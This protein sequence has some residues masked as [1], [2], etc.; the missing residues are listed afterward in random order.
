MFDRGSFE[1]ERGVK[2][3]KEAEKSE[4]IKKREEKYVEVENK[5]FFAVYSSFS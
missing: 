2:A 4:E 3:E 5:E 1:P